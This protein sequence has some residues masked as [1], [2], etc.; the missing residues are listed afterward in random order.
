MK[1]ILHILAKDARHLWA[2]ILLSVAVISAF[3]L[4]CP[5]DWR[6]AEGMHSFNAAVRNSPGEVQLFVGILELLVSASWWLLISNLIHDERLVGDR[7]FWLTRPY[8]WKKLLVAKLLFLFAFLYL[9]LFI[10]EC[11]LLAAA[12]F[13]PFSHL[14]GLLFNLLLISGILI[15]PL[16]AI[17]TITSN[18]ARMTIVLLG[19]LLSIAAFFALAFRINLET[20]TLPWETGAHLVLLV[21]L[22]AAAVV[23]QYAT[24]NTRASVLLLVAFPVLYLSIGEF[25]VPSQVVV[26]RSYPFSA[27]AADA[28]V[29]LSYS[30]SGFNNPVTYPGRLP[31]EVSIQI[32]LEVSGIADH[33]VVILDAVRAAV[34]TTGSFRWNSAWQL[35]YV[36]KIS[37]AEKTAHIGFVM[38]VAVYDQLKSAPLTVHLTLALTQARAGRFTT[39]SLPA[40][41]FSVPD[42]GV[43]S[44]EGALHD[45]DEVGGI[46]CLSALREPHLTRIQLIAH[47][48]SST[49]DSAQTDAGVPNS[50]WQG[51]LDTWPAQMSISSVKF[52]YGAWPSYVGPA[53]R[54]ISGLH[55]CRGAPITFTRYDL[56]RRAQVAVT[57]QNFQLPTLTPAQRS[58]I[59]NP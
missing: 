48:E 6:A 36:T 5:A 52:P 45:P 35:L 53:G 56:S 42:F 57:I 58:V 19:I 22:C 39:V 9:P 40:G 50:T 15:L 30:P 12:G 11:A 1:Q 16:V 20:M 41:S 28:P 27:A 10:A 46:F 47:N 13:S 4:A 51:S 59:T 3:A 18:F 29:Q 17:A 55:L 33:S 44:P 2:E 7:Q 23:S 14:A 32:P 54:E 25:I 37:P 8:E 26:N 34:E 49:C 43:C 38:P 24:R 31:R 21:C